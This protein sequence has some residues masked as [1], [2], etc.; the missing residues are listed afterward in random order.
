MLQRLFC[1][2]C[3]S[4]LM[5]LFCISLYQWRI[6]VRRSG[7]PK[8]Y[9]AA[10]CTFPLDLSWPLVC[11]SLLVTNIMFSF[12][13]KNTEFFSDSWEWKLPTVV[14]RVWKSTNAN[15]EIFACFYL[16]VMRWYHLLLCSLNWHFSQQCSTLYYSAIRMHGSSSST[17]PDDPRSE[18]EP[19]F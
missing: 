1:S 15:L 2:E 16:T 11:R 13:K 12:M 9:S 4:H 5:S 10:R 6:F 14:F 19:Q 8:R 3:L 17:E 7:L 18:Y